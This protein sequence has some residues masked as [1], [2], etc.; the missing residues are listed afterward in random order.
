VTKAKYF[1]IQV[2]SPDPN[3]WSSN[4]IDKTLEIAPPQ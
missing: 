4:K 3:K 2:I 1:V